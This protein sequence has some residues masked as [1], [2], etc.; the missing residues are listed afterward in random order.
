MHVPAKTTIEFQETFNTQRGE[1][2]GNS[3][4]KRVDGQQEDSLGDGVLLS[5]ETQDYSQDWTDTGRPA[6]C[7][8]ETNNEGA[9]GSASAFYPVQAFVSIKRLYL[10]NS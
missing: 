8:C 7:E 9:P 1:Q 2:K 10:K 5:G 4:T 3:E 6:E